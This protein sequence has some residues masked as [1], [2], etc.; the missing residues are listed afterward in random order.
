VA[1]KKVKTKK[2]PAESKK[3][4]VK[5]DNVSPA[6]FEPKPA[7]ES[8]MASSAL[9]EEPKKD[10]RGGAR[11]GA[12]RPKGITDEL[13]IVN[14]LP[15]KANLQMVPV[16]QMPFR[17]WARR[18]G[19]PEMALSK[20]DAEE[21]ALPIYQLLSIYFPGK[22]PEI[23]WIWLNFTGVTIR[24][25]DSR[26]DLLAQKRSEKQALQVLAN[27]AQRSASSLAYGVGGAG[28]AGAR[29]LKVVTVDEIE[30]AARPKEE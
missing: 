29:P 14:K 11:P 7:F 30:R 26:L 28:P 20:E 12:G 13:S 3:V 27:T 8:A 2:K 15:E 19:V 18:T 1:K 21:W 6:S 16:I 10:G 24:I 25:M 23:A 4:I 5:A 22:I 17:F 9:I